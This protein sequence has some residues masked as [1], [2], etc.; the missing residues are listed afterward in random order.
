M[1]AREIIST[2][3]DSE[4]NGNY[5]HIN[6]SKCCMNPGTENS[7]FGKHTTKYGKG[8]DKEATTSKGCYIKT[9]VCLGDEGGCYLLK[10]EIYLVSTALYIVTN[11]GQ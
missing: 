1:H 3:L 6:H 2:L 9:R 4:Y 7:L 5:N 11:Y 10:N 8:T